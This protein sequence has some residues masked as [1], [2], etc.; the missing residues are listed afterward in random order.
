M[1]QRVSS[2]PVHIGLGRERWEI[3]VVLPLKYQSGWEKP[4]GVNFAGV[5]THC[6]CCSRLQGMLNGAIVGSEVNLRTLND[7]AGVICSVRPTLFALF[8]MEHSQSFLPCSFFPITLTIFKQNLS[9]YYC[10]T[11][12]VWFLLC[13]LHF[14]SSGW[15]PLDSAGRRCKGRLQGWWRRKKGLAPSSLF[16]V[17]IRVSPAT[18][19]T[20]A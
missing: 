13:K 5:D 12:K 7:S 16:P 20:P 15:S 19:L 6:K 11:Y 9:I 4:E 10:A 8:K 3:W 14:C 1:S 2:E 17:P 18:D